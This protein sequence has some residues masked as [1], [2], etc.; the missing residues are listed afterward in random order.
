MKITRTEAKKQDIKYYFTGK[1]CKRGHVAKRL[2]SNHSCSACGTLTKSK[3][4][5]KY[6]NKNKDKIKA[7]V[8]KWVDINKADVHARL[9][10]YYSDNSEVIK[11]RSKQYYYDNYDVCI[12]T[13]AKYRRINYKEINRKN[14]PNVRLRQARKLNATPSWYNHDKVKAIYEESH[15]LTLETNIQHHVDHIYPLKGKTVCG[16]HSHENLQ[17]LPAKENMTKGNKHPDV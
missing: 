11:N 4:D 8:K 15:R 17:I 1:P 13:R 6:Y 16:L 5:K 7:N 12:E 2:V 14:L 9:R 3:N 10:R